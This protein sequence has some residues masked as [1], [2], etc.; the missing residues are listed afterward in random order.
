MADPVSD[1][2]VSRARER[3]QEVEAERRRLD[4]LARRLEAGEKLYSQIVEAKAKAKTAKIRIIVGNTSTDNGIAI[5]EHLLA[6]ALEALCGV[7]SGD[8][9]AAI[10]DLEASRG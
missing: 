4:G 10:A 9:A 1:A 7:V 3:Y 5:P 8:L 6:S 2:L